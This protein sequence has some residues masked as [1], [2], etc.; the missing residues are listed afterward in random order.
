MLI[1]KDI[2]IIGKGNTMQSINITNENE[3]VIEDVVFDN[4]TINN[5]NTIEI[6]DCVFMNANKKNIISNSNSMTL[7]NCI[8]KNNN[9][10]D[11][12]CIEIISPNIHTVIDRCTFNNN[13]GSGNATC[14]S[15]KHV[16]ELE[17]KNTKFIN[18]SS[19]YTEGACIYAYGNSAFYKNIFYNNTVKYEIRAIKS[20][21]IADKNIFDGV[22]T[23][24]SFE[25]NS[26]GD[27]DFNYWGGATKRS[28]INIP[29]NI[30]VNNWLI[31]SLDKE[32]NSTIITPNITQYVN[33]L[34][35][36]I[37]DIDIHYNEFD[38]KI[39]NT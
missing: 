36:E 4:S 24:I 7:D 14:V 5:S 22:N 39:D 23:P 29:E 10:S 27:I 12:S 6:S 37:T 20:K 17:I 38:S 3:V 9:V 30:T 18:N 11:S 33:T 8:F 16:N 35:T 31:G 28:E 25:M 1:N 19:S 21:I 32:E 15:S 34:E 26:T 13:S 2:T